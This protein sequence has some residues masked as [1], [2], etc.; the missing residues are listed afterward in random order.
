MDI[1]PGMTGVL[2]NFLS[3]SHTSLAPQHSPHQP[4]RPPSVPPATGPLHMLFS[5]LGMFPLNFVFLPSKLCTWLSLA[6]KTS[7]LLASQL[8]HALINDWFPHRNEN[9]V[10]TALTLSVYN[11]RHIE[12][13]N[14]PMCM[15]CCPTLQTLSVESTLRD[16]GRL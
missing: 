13:F 1:W 7:Q 11:G 10:G 4:R 6:G 15:N 14:A 8:L 12:Q 2:D 9:S 3:P 16:S 5:P